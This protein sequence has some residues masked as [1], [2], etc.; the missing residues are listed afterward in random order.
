MTSP[1]ILP[2]FFYRGKPRNPLFKTLQILSKKTSHL[3]KIHIAETY[4]Y[5]WIMQLKT[6]NMLVPNVSKRSAGRGRGD[7]NCSTFVTKS[8]AT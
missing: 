1:V 6:A 8:H 2:S 7:T 4:S 5:V 3:S